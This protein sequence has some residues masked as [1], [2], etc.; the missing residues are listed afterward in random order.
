MELVKY[1][2][3]YK[4]IVIDNKDPSGFHRVRVRIPKLHGTIVQS[5]QK[6]ASGA[7]T[8]KATARY[9]KDQGL[10]W[11]EVAFPFGS[12][13]PP[14]IGQ[15]VVVGFINSD[16]SQPVVLGWLGYEYTSSEE[17]FKPSNIEV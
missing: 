9:V 14:E 7:Q 11:C 6:K 16:S 1:S 15:V 3:L 17:P 8:N 2:G 10:P 4:G 5:A 12:D 13:I